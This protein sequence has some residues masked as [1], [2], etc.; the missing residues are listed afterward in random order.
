MKDVAAVLGWALGK[1]GAPGGVDKIPDA[2]AELV[3][4]RVLAH[5]GSIEVGRAASLIKL[6]TIMPRGSDATV[7]E[8]GIL[9]SLF[10]PNLAKANVLARGAFVVTVRAELAGRGA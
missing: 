8:V 6:P 3:G 1:A 9:A 5:T 10:S 7:T 2:L 4:Q